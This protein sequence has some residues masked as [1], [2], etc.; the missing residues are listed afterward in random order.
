MQP[1]FT[2]QRCLFNQCWFLH[3]IAGINGKCVLLNLWWRLLITAPVAIADQAA[4]TFTNPLVTIT[5]PRCR[6]PIRG[7]IYHSADEN[8]CSTMSFTNSRWRFPKYKFG[9]KR[10]KKGTKP[11]KKFAHSSIYNDPTFTK[12]KIHFTIPLNHL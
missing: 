8:Y 2:E 12:K 11:K 10:P 9:Q 3:N 7:V 5:V 4:V 1:R 6:L